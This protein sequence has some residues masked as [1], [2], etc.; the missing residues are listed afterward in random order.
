[1]ELQEI[2]FELERKVLLEK[3][4]HLLKQCC[5]ELEQG[6]DTE[7]VDSKY[8]KKVIKRSMCWNINRKGLNKYIK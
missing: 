8:F 7:D 5:E 2:E 4:M 1:M 6:L 3:I